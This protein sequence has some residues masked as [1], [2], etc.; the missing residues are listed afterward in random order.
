MAKVS[1][2]TNDCRKGRCAMEQNR[3]MCHIQE[4]NPRTWSL[5]GECYRSLRQHC[6]E[7]GMGVPSR[8]WRRDLVRI[9]RTRGHSG[10]IGLECAG[11]SYAQI[12]DVVSR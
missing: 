12:E 10:N 6:E 4:G 8:R 11:N 5:V 3:M 7:R 9:F 1:A 2:G